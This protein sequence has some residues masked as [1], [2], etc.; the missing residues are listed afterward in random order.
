MLPAVGPFD[1][2]LQEGDGNDLVERRLRE[3]FAG[4]MLPVG[5]GLDVEQRCRTVARI[6]WTTREVAS[7]A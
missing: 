5:H 6:T 1:L 3:A 2:G 4:V 7:G